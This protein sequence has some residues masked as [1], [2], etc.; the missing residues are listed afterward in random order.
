MVWKIFVGA[1]L[2]VAFLAIAA[3]FASAALGSGQDWDD[4]EG[5]G[6]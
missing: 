6:E 5:K 4:D 2:V 3:V 1:V